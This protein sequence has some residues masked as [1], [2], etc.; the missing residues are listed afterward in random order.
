MHYKYDL[1]T[2]SSLFTAPFEL[3]PGE[4]MLLL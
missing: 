2:G 4:V 3:D 1:Y